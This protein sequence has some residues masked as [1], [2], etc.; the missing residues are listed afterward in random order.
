[1]PIELY[2][3]SDRIGGNI[4]DMIAQLTYAHKTSNSIHYNRERLRVYNT[5]NQNYNKTIFM[6]ML[7]D[8]IDVHNILTTE[9][10]TDWTDLA[11]PS[12]FEVL[13][14]TLLTL[15][16]D[17]ISYFKGNNI[18]TDKMRA[19]FLEK[20]KARGYDIPFNPEKTI[21]VHLRMEDVK[22]RGDYDGSVCANYMRDRIESGDI[23]GTEVLTPTATPDPWCQ[24]QGPLDVD[25]VQRQID[26]AIKKNP[27]HEVILITNPNEDTSRLPY[28]VISNP[29]EC[30][31]LFLLCNA[32]TLI[33]SR[34]NF[35]LVS[36]F[37]GIGEEVYTPLWGHLPCYGLYTKYDECKF[38]YFK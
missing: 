11:A 17:I 26:I 33:L 14:K 1:M 31:D 18:Y 5:Y 16:M 9:E 28:R 20:G 37:F 22:D 25:K 15:D 24:M 38:N 35:A 12:H 19:L 3:S 7:F 30:Y 36:L 34:S 13:T 2:G 27:N 6:E 8:L 21:L 32:K 4:I 23:P 29:D 10:T